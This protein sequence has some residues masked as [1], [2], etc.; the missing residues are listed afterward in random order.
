MAECFVYPCLAI[1]GQPPC[2]RFVSRPDHCQRLEI[3]PSYQAGMATATG[4]VRWVFDLHPPNDRGIIATL[5]YVHQAFAYNAG[6]LFD[7]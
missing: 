6:S 2:V 5:S 4:T 3:S 1:E 7:E